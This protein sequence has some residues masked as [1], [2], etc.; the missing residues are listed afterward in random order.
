MDD[1]RP[2]DP[3]PDGT[4]DEEELSPEQ[5]EAQI[6]D[7]ISQ[8]DSLPGPS[9]EALVDAALEIVERAWDEV[10]RL[11]LGHPT[12]KV[13]GAMLHAGRLAREETPVTRAY[14]I[15]SATSTMLTGQ[16]RPGES[17]QA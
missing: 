6:S 12:N 1:E 8:A 3:A 2:V 4:D 16:V 17:P 14:W 13:I 5:L 9:S 7:F 10:E 11:L 15:A